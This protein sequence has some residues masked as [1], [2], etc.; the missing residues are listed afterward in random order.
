MIRT[1]FLAYSIVYVLVRLTAIRTESKLEGGERFITPPTASAQRTPADETI[2]RPPVQPEGVSFRTR[3]PT[4]GAD[5]QLLYLRQGN[6]PTDGI[7]VIRWDAQNSSQS[8][9][10]FA[11][12]PSRLPRLNLAQALDV[13][14]RLLCHFSLTQLPGA[15]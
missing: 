10:G 13:D 8:R 14:A 2:L 4:L 3:S 12:Q 1:D 6:A 5:F 7:Q 11:T 15:S 9:F